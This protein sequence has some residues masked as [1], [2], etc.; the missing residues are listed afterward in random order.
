VKLTRKNF[1]QAP[2]IK[3]ANLILVIAFALSAVALS[4]GQQAAN[5]INTIAGGG[6]TPSSPLSLDLPGPTAVLKDGQG[7]LYITAPAS[8]YVFE[9]TAGGTVQNYTGLGWGYFAGD[10]GPVAAA[11][12]GLV[13]DIVEDSLGNFYLTDIADSR[14]RE[15]S[16]GIIN[17]VIG[18]GTKCDIATGTNVCGD[19][20]PVAQANLNIPTSIALDNAGNIYITDTV[21]NRIRVANMGTATLTVAGTSIPAGDIQTI[22]GDGTA[23]SIATNPTCGDGGPASAAEVNNPMGIFVD[24]AG[25]IFIADTHDHEIREIANALSGGTTIAAYAGQTGAACPLSTSGCNDGSLATKGLLRLPQGI[26]LDGNGNGYI[27]DTG[28]NKAR[29]VNGN[30]GVINTMAGNGNQGFAGDGGLAQQAELDAPN[31]VYVDSSSNIYVADTGNQRVRQFTLAGNIQTIA[32][33]SLGDGPALSAQLAN[34]YSVSSG[35]GTIYFTDQANNRVRALTNNSGVYTVSTIAGTG[36]LGFSG[37]GG[38]ATAATMNAPSGLALD[39]L[40][41]LY[42]TDTNNLVIR[43]VNLSTGIIKT[44]AGTANEGC[45]PPTGCG[46]NGPATSAAFTGPLGIAT[47]SAGNLYIADYFGYRVR[48]VNMGSTTTKVAGISAKPGY[49]VTVAGTGSQGDC[50]FNNTCGKAAIK[51]GLNHPGATAVDSSGNLYISDQWNNAVRVVTT[52]GILNAYALGGKPGPTGDG[53]PA[54]KGGMWNPL[55]VTLDPEG[56]LYISGGN[57]ELVQRVDVLTTGIGGPHEIGTAVGNA[58]NATLGGFAGDGGPAI[59]TSVRMDNLGSSV[60]GSGNLYIADAGNN[61]IRYVPLAPAGSPSVATLNLGTWPIGQA[62]GGLS[63]NFTSTGGEDLSLNSIGVS[64]TNSSEFTTTNTCGTLPASM[65]PQAACKVTVTLTPTGYGPQTA[66]LNFNDNG[67]NSPQTVTLTGSGP[68]FS[69]SASPNAV[70]VNEGQTGASTI[71]LTPVAK[72]N[73]LVSLSCSGA[74]ANS[75]CTITPNQVTLNGSSASTAALSIQTQNTTPTGTYT[76]VVTSTFQSLVE[77]AKIT[78][79]V[80]K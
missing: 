34:P 63:V 5:T 47:D 23:C 27:A 45:P 76:L 35:S 25:D 17:T 15:V 10:G 37:D 74:P 26:Y 2:A 55:L 4:A 77:T 16:N 29:F 49:I 43:Q 72:F 51:T 12:V 64:G 32:G 22:V 21:D 28:D 52:A 44:V 73:Q 79:K 24:A 62:G 67:P 70:K 71:T 42:F 69:V 54:S 14:I 66:T 65:G 40:G 11:N 18:N 48:A 68:T 1:S 38:P 9:L 61:R 50:S 31:G 53:G 33:G 60:D 57:D 8:A 59:G 3:I 39:S 20:G 78:L 46:D 30:N 6:T 19:G 75:T 58:G 13:T 56:D 7:N 36:S 41:N 80:N